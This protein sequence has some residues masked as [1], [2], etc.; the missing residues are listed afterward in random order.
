MR[1]DKQRKYIY[2]LMKNLGWVT[3]DGEPDLDSLAGFVRERFHVER[4]EW[5]TVK[6][7]SDIIEGLKAIK[8]RRED[9]QEAV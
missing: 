5:V 7:A 1:T 2:G 3:E 6:T 8:A 9:E 4:L